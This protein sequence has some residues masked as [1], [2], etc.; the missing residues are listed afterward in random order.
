MKSDWVI[1]LTKVLYFYVTDFKAQLSPSNNSYNSWLLLFS[2]NW[3]IIEIFSFFW[4]FMLSLL[5]CFALTNLCD[6]YFSLL[7]S[8]VNAYFSLLESNPYIISLRR[9]SSS[10]SILVLPYRISFASYF[11]SCYF[12]NAKKL[13]YSGSLELWLFPYTIYLWYYSIIIFRILSN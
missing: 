4:F 1:N 10:P 2:C 9:L 6:T 13:I 5:F 8:R 11:E 7:L 12:L 3:F